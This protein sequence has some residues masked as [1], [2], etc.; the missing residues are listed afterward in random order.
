M[1]TTLTKPELSGRIKFG[2]WYNLLHARLYRRI[3]MVLT[4]VQLAMGS[5]VINGLI[6][7]FSRAD[8]YAAALVAVVGIVQQLASLQSHRAIHQ[9]A[10]SD[11]LRLEKDL[12]SLECDLAAGKLY[13]LY[14]KY[15]DG[16]NS[17]EEIA[18][19]IISQMHDPAT[20]QKKLSCLAKAINLIV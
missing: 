15:P 16:L 3:D 6:K 14:D 17:I 4:A 19:G 1:A 9:M 10:A 13:D 12:D 20:P 7:D 2:Y 5:Y 11:Y 8:A 18:Q